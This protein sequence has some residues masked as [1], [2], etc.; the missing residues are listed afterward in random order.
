M[1]RINA[2]TDVVIQQSFF[3]LTLFQVGVDSIKEKGKWVKRMVT[4]VVAVN[5][6]GVHLQCFL[7]LFLRSVDISFHVIDFRKSGI[8]SLG[9]V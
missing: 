2:Q 6:H 9:M 8:Q 1:L 5:G 7:M 3:E 4:F